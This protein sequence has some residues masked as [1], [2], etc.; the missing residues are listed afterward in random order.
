MLTQNLPDKLQLPFL[1]GDSPWGSTAEPAACPT[2]A[3]VL[4]LC[5]PYSGLKT[6]SLKWIFRK[7]VPSFW[8]LKMASISSWESP[9]RKLLSLCYFLLF[10]LYQ[11][12]KHLIQA[13]N[14]L[15]S[16]PSTLL[17][18][19]PKG[20][21]IWHCPS[22]SSSTN[23]LMQSCRLWGFQLC[24]QKCFLALLPVPIS[25]MGAAGCRTAEKLW[26]PHTVLWEQEKWLNWFLMVC[27][28]SLQVSLNSWL[29]AE[30]GGDTYRN[31]GFSNFLIS[32]DVNWWYRLKDSAAHL[33]F[34][35]HT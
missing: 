13:Y 4:T 32:C 17:I 6:C 24:H 18:A 27:T 11:A 15:Q 30:K 28:W 20:Q 5:T 29:G 35:T 23:C 10:F 34:I 7:D 2:G 31:T 14:A 1:P 12:H 26:L 19:L 9:N 25:L 16:C 21:M 3:A 8:F 33:E 22:A